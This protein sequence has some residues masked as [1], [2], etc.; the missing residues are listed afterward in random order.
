[1]S[2]VN[3][4]T[5]QVLSVQTHGAGATHPAEWFWSGSGGCSSVEL[6]E[7]SDT[8]LLCTDQQYLQR[9]KQRATGESDSDDVGGQ[10]SS[11]WVLVLWHQD[12]EASGES[13]QGGKSVRTNNKPTLR[14]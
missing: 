3:N 14:D 6:A 9:T 4:K 12:H 11:L 13:R 2:S 5:K 10:V 1:M 7:R 8:S